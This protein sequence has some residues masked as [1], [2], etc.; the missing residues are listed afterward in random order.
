MKQERNGKTPL[1]GAVRI[2][3]QYHLSI[4]HFGR[5]DA[6]P[7]PAPECSAVSSPA[8]S[9]YKQR[10]KSERVVCTAASPPW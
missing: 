10:R 6:S 1:E 3:I 8:A 4:Q 5:H 7:V 9:P 2:E